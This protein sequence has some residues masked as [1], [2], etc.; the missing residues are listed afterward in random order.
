MSISASMCTMYP[1]V[2]KREQN[3][4]LDSLE[5]VNF[6]ITVSHLLA[7]LLTEPGSLARTVRDLNCCSIFQLPF[8]SSTLFNFVY[9]YHSWGSMF[10]VKGQL[11]EIFPS[12]R[13]D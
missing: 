6:N 10:V 3:R 8:P 7:V 4:A 13:L 11:S 5:G 9:N 1:H 12:T 2:P